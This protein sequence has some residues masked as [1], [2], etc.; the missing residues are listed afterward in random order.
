MIDF[1]DH[2]RMMK[3]STVS[4]DRNVITASL[5]ALTDGLEYALIGK[6]D[7]ECAMF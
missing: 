1:N 3:W 6:Q 2:E 4:V 5:N 7:D